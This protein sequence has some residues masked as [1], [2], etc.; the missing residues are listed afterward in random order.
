MRAIIV[1]AALALASAC[2]RDSD[3]AVRAAPPAKSATSP[4]SKP[5]PT[6][7]APVTAMDQSNNEADV[8]MTQEVRRALVNDSTL[9]VLAKNVTVVSKD[10]VVTLRGT[11]P[12]DAERVQIGAIAESVAGVHSVVNEIEVEN[13]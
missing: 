2:S 10:G 7:A 4:A 6:S 3:S 9:S 11:V 13:H 12:S 8:N 1:C 5:P